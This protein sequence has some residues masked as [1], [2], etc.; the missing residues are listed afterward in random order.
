MEFNLADLFE[1]AV[2][3]FADRE[4]IVAD[5]KRRSYGEM[6]A[7]ASEL[8]DVIVNRLVGKAGV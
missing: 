3:H 4:Y 2:D 8:A 1:H 5:G 7:R 6:E